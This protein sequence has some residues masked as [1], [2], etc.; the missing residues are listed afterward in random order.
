[1]NGRDVARDPLRD[2]PDVQA[3]IPEVQVGIP[4]C[5][6]VSSTMV[7]GREIRKDEVGSSLR[8]RSFPSCV[9][10]VRDRRSLR[11]P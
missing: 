10:H 2:V 9:S 11:R 5:G 7:S 3:G 4:G 8:L 6:L 1:M